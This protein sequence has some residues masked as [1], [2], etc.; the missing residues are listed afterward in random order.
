MSNSI[1]LLAAVVLVV[2]IAAGYYAYPHLWYRVGMGEARTSQ[3]PIGS[4]TVYKSTQGNV[5]FLYLE[6]SLRQEY[7]LDPS[8]G[9]VGIPNGGQFTY[10]SS[11][12]YSSDIRVPFVSSKSAKVDTDMNIV[13]NDKIIEFTIRPGIRISAE[14]NNF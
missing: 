6:D 11:I 14:R 7:I 13:M 10:V 3:G 5:L 9:D 8:T 2:I 4:V 1:R 12:A